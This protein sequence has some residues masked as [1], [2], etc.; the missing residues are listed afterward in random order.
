MAFI[1][2]QKIK[3][4]IYFY[5][6]ESYW[7]KNK[8]QPRQ[9]RIFLGKKD[10][11]TKEI[12]PPKKIM[13]PKSYTCKEYGSFYFLN[14]IS[15]K[16]ELKET[17]KEIFIDDWEKIITCAFF[18]I[19]EGKPL[20]LCNSWLENTYNDFLSNLP[21]QRITE[22][23]KQLGKDYNSRFK[24][25]KVWGERKRKDNKYIVFDISSISSYSKIIDYVEWGFNRDGERLPQINL[26]IIFGEPSSLPIFYNIYQG[27]IKDVST[28]ENILNIMEDLELKDIIFVLDK[29]FYSSYNLKKISLK[30]LKL[31]IPLPFSTN[32]AAEIIQRHKDNILKPI[33]AFRFKDRV[34]FCVKDE[35][36]IEGERFYVYLYYDEKMKSEKSE[37][38]LKEIIELESCVKRVD[39]K[40][41]DGLKKYLSEIFNG[42]ERL[43]NIKEVNG[44]FEIERGEVRITELLNS[45]GKMI[46]LYNF[47]IEKEE[48]LSFYRRKDKV[49]R[50]F[51]NMKNELNLKRLR[52]HSHEAMEGRLFISFITL[53]LYSYIGKV[54]KEKD[55]YKD[56]TIEEVMYE[57]KKIKVIELAG[58]RKILSEISKKQKE[59][60]KNF[61]I[62]I[63]KT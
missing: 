60:F 23:L 7:D 15:E 22:L 52:V 51:D 41:K 61:D 33:N 20:Y 43:F 19:C 37:R 30:G 3:K 29:G 10:P 49:E 5:Q 16:I 26:G 55:L 58:G 48:V 32:L 18:E 57:L 31:I 63:P 27:S 53:I 45:F 59:L 34:L 17:L 44:K 47:A 46:L 2:K 50:L 21:S 4:H 54:M 14:K 24:F 13:I 25:F 9:K 39:F 6:I 35:V 42:W 40:K 12:I 38:L 1:F 36:E 28:L 11:K 56:Y 8:K 62:E